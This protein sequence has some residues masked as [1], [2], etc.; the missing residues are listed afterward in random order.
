MVSAKKRERILTALL[1]T[2]ILGFLVLIGI[3]NLFHFCFELNADIAS[4]VVLGKLIWDSREIIPRTWYVAAETRIICTANVASLFYGLTHNM[5]LSAGLASCMMTVLIVGSVFYF[6]GRGGICL[7][8]KEKLLF[9][10]L[11]LI[12]PAG[13][14]FLELLYLFA[15]YYAIHIVTLFFTFGVYLEACR[16]G[17]IKWIKLAICVLPALILGMQGARGILVIYGPLFG[18]AGI[19]NLYDLYCGR[20]LH[21]KDMVVGLWTVVLLAAGFWGMSFPFA[22]RQELSRNIRNGFPKL[23]N[24][25][26][27]DMLRAMGFNGSQN[28]FSIV[29]TVVLTLIMGYLVIDIL[30]RMCRKQEIDAAERGYLLLCSSPVVTA[31]IVAFTTVEDSD[32]YYFLFSFVMAYAAVLFFRKLKKDAVLGRGLR[33]ELCHFI[34]S[35]II[36]IVSIDRLNTIYIPVLKAEEPSRGEAFEVVCFLEEH[37]F[38][39]AYSTFENA[40]LMTVLSNGKTKVSAVGSLEKMDI[41]KWMSSTDWYVPNVPYEERTAYVVPESQTGAFNAFLAVHGENMKLETQIG[42]FLIYSSDYNFSCLE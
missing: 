11:C 32:R 34:L 37:D 18:M 13:F 36:L 40:N 10:F 5:S 4:D 25:V 20:K 26:I 35:L 27:P 1:A 42:N 2:G 8:R 14:H 31:F 19:F 17:R 39:T 33:F 29:C 41:C 3:T 7:T 22:A 6:S 21:K 24:E 38:R 16:S 12:L 23:W 28:L 9:G 30:Y 15:S